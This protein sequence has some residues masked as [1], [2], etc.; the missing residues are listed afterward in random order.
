[1][2]SFREKPTDRAF[3]RT[4]WTIDGNNHLRPLIQGASPAIL[5][6]LILSLNVDG[7]AKSRRTSFRS[8]F[9]TSPRTENQILTLYLIRSP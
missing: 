6:A 3:A 5:V 2:E 7:F 9:D 4:C 1:M 8:W